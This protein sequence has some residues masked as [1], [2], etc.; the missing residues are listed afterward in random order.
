MQ[1][2]HN[3]VGGRE[4][5]FGQKYETLYKNSPLAIVACYYKAALGEGAP[6]NV[7]LGIKF[8]VKQ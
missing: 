3:K 2:F 4:L 1:S 7:M 6:T 8:W 5:N